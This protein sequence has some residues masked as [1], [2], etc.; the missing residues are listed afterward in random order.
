MEEIK[1]NPRKNYDTLNLNRMVAFLKVF[2]TKT[3][4]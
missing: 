2:L 4:G 1:L 3:K